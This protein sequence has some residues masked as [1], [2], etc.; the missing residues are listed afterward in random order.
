MIP[1]KRVSKNDEYAYVDILYELPDNKLHRED[2]PA[3]FR[4]YAT[5]ACYEAWAYNDKLHRY[6]GPARTY[7]CGWKQYYIHGLEVTKEVVKWLSERGYVWD[8]MSDVEKWELEIFMR[9]L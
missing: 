1:T 6:G 4:I 7:A 2:G 8:T 3:F 5:G 9:S